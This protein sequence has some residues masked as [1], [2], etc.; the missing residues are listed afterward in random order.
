MAT[1]GRAVMFAGIT[2]IASMLGILLMGQPAMTSFAF[3]VVLA[4][5]VVMAASVTLVP[6]LRGFAG[7]NIERLHVP[8]VGKTVGSP[9]GTRWYRWSRCIQRR[10]PVRRHR[11]ARRTPGYGRAVPGHP[12]RFPDGKNDVPGATTRA[13]YDLLE[14]GLGPAFSS[15]M[16]LIAEGAAGSDV[17]GS[18]EAVAAELRQVDGVAFVSTPVVNQAGD[19]AVLSLV[20]TT[21]PQEQATEDLVETLREESILAATAKPA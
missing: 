8:F 3:S 11:R 15:P 4:V 6:A 10:P 13:A 19:T 14:T 21:S 2:V 9:T 5:L 17:L 7:R 16:L 20:P 12:L 18:A 1:A